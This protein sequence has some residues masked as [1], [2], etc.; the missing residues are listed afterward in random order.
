MTPIRIHSPRENITHHLLSSVI[1]AVP[2]N[3]RQDDRTGKKLEDSGKL[4]SLPTRQ[5]RYAGTPER[6][7]ALRSLAT[8]L[9]ARDGED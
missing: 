7:Y 4:G 2:D 5:G 6:L 3:A 1:P 8:V 9:R